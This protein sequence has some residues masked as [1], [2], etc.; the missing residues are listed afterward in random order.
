ML[1]DELPRKTSSGLS[2]ALLT[3]PAGL[4]R[5]RPDWED[6]L[7]RSASAEPMLSPDWLGAWWQVY[8]GP[9]Q[10]RVGAFY[11]GHRLVGLAPLCRRRFWYRPGI[12]FRRLEF[13]GSDVDEG[14]GVGSEYLNVVARSG[15]EEVVA[16]AFV[17][18]VAAGAFGPWDEVV[19]SAMDGLGP[20]PDLLTS[21][22]HRSGLPATCV[23]TTEAPYIPLPATWNLYVQGLPKKKRYGIVRALRDFEVWNGGPPQV[24]GVTSPA[25]L[26]KGKRILERLHNE[27]WDAAGQRGAFRA[28]RFA[29]FHDL[30]LPRLLAGG[31]LELL[32]LV[33]GGEPV[34]ALYNIVANN[35]VYFYQC[36]RKLDVPAG[37]RPG[38]V[39]LALA[40]QHAI[41]AS[42]RE[43]DFLGGS[44]Q[45]KT[46][47]ALATRPLVE[48]RAAR[49]GWRETLRGWADQGLAYARAARNRLRAAVGWNN[50]GPVNKN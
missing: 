43:F 8:R 45:Y 4:E 10:L 39:L 17:Q 21:A 35:K 29:A 23:T 50:V 22:F 11:D 19:L 24:E 31:Q 26:A 36:G 7:A 42:R 2:L 33:V 37:Q 47:F 30:L 32:W 18:A 9:R 5:L 34:A 1:I 25:E 27:R 6:L 28:G 48:V 3:E 14:D 12:P 20:M 38:I 41:A 16:R 15:S 46:Q 13:L 44:A 40:V 49:P